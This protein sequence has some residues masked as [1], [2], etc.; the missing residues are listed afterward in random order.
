MLFVYVLALIG[1]VALVGL[2]AAAL[3]QPPA[4]RGEDPDPYD[5]ALEAVARLQAGAWQ[6]VQQLRQLDDGKGR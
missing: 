3:M 2:A 4:P 6:A 1:L 5:E